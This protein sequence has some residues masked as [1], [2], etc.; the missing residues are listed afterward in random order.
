MNKKGTMIFGLIIYKILYKI[1][2]IYFALKE[3]I[4]KLNAIVG[5]NE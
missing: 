5:G 4:I 3:I 2:K 1:R